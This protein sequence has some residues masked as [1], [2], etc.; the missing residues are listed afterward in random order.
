M[1]Y[2]ALKRDFAFFFSYVAAMIGGELI[3]LQQE[4]TIRGTLGIRDLLV[5]PGNFY[6]S[7]ILVIFVFYS[8]AA[9]VLMR[10]HPLKKQIFPPLK[11][12]LCYNVFKEV[13][14]EHNFFSTD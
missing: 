8:T 13:I 10:I 12:V 14:N 6:G 3:A 11:F 9:Y 7:Y 5:P 1:V 2:L 4:Y